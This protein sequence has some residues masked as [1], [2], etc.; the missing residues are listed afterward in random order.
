MVPESLSQGS[1]LI[2]LGMAW[3]LGFFKAP[4]GT[5]RELLLRGHGEE[6]PAQACRAGPSPRAAWCVR[7]ATCKLFI[8]C[9][10]YWVNIDP[11]LWCPRSYL[12]FSRVHLWCSGDTLGLGSANRETD[13]TEIKH[14]P[15]EPGARSS[16]GDWVWWAG[17]SM[18]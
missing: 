10:N 1:E 17:K 16:G 18:C 3:A 5:A 2:S 7:E 6:D 8:A 14:V 15:K 11:R 12:L 13:N 9:L 4:L